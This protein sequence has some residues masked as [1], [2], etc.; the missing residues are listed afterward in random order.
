VKEATVLKNWNALRNLGGRCDDWSGEGKPG[1]RKKAFAAAAKSLC[2]WLRDDVLDGVEGDIRFNPGGPAVSG[3][4]TLHTDH[5]YV[6]FSGDFHND[7]S[8]GVMVRTCKGR[9]DYSGGANNW[10]RSKA[11]VATLAATV[12]ALYALGVRDA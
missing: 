11:D 4:V 9:K 10:V 12:S 3:E 8:L 5:V 7:P 2:R 1:P 6:Q